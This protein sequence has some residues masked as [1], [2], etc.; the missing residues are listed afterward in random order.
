MNVSKTH[1]DEFI[2]A[3]ENRDVDGARQLAYDHWELSRHGMALFVHPDPLDI[4]LESGA[5]QRD[6]ACANP[7]VIYR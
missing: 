2:V 1:H 3:I 5:R 7:D 6:N 4:S